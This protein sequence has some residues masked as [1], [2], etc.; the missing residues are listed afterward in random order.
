MDEP[1][2]LDI[3]V[4]EDDADASANVRDILELDG[5][6][7]AT[8]GTAADALGRRDLADFV[9]IVLDRKLPD[10]MAEE[11]M[12]RLRAAAPGAAIVVVTGYSDLQGSI[13]ALR[14]G[15]AD[16]ILKPLNADELRVRIGR[17][18]ETKRLEEAG[19]SAERRYRILVQNS[20]DIITAFD[21]DGNILYLSPSIEWLLGYKPEDRIGKNIFHN[22]IVHPDD[23]AAKRGFFEKALSRP[24]VPITANFRLR[25]RDGSH[26]HIEAV[27]TNLLEDPD[28]GAI[29]ANYRDITARMQMESALRQTEERFRVLVEAAECM[30]VMLRPDRSIAYFSPFAEHLTGYRAAEILGQNYVPLLLPKADR[31]AVIEEFDRAFAGTPTP[32]YQN[33]VV[34]RDGSLRWMAWNC[35]ALSDFEGAP[36]LLKVGQDITHVKQAQERALQAERLAA[37]GQMVAGLAHESR[38]ALQRSQACLEM[39]A[40]LVRGRAQEL[41]LIDRIQQAQDH[42]HHLYEDVR[43]Y[44]APIILARRECDLAETWR[45]AWADLERQRQGHVTTLRE[46]T[47]G[48]DTHC[49]ADSFR[50]KQVFSNILE[51]ALAACQEPVEICVRCAPD[52]IEDQAAVRI[53]V[54]DNGPGLSLE[55]R[56]NIFEPFFTTKT[57]G[58]GLGM[59]IVRRIVEAHGGRVAVGDGDGGAAGAEILITLPKGKT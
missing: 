56:R 25:H 5:H 43:G 8:V 11:L 49:V 38:N 48:I 28:V 58:T 7:I 42:L 31:Q 3:L 37:V 17:I 55:T 19:R 33:P 20:N 32:G 24:G 53:S 10:A 18:A 4:V 50:M 39:L 44:S 30:I 16:Y 12:P 22:S 21:F 23:I 26:R 51:N 27:G 29:T 15:A 9:V 35:R 47:R 13:A 6:R 41:N 2:P 54:S 40:R 46:D 1:T 52:W 36:A 34:C 59:A 45:E 57:K 14:H